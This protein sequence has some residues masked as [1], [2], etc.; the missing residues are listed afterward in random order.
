[1]L[2]AFV[3]F[4]VGGIVDSFCGRLSLQ[5]HRVDHLSCILDSAAEHGWRL[6]L[7][8]GLVKHR[9]KAVFRFPKFL[10]ESGKGLI[11]RTDYGAKLGCA[12][13]LEFLGMRNRPISC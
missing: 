4:L 9:A 5:L 12:S 6:A 3:G 10:Y 13:A 11:E 1:M 8:F 2:L 7:K